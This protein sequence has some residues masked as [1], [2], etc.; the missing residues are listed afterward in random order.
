M[1]ICRGLIF[2]ALMLMIAIE[3]HSQPGAGS[4]P[5]LD[6]GREYQ[7]LR[8]R[9][10]PPQGYTRVTVDE[11]SFALWLRRLPL[12]PPGSRV[13]LFNGKPKADQTVHHAVIA[14]DTGSRNLQQCADAVIRLRAEYLF[15]RNRLDDI[16]F[17][18]TSGHPAAFPRWAQGER[19]M[20][21]GNR[22]TWRHRADADASHASLRRYLTNL[23]IYAG[24]YSLERE[25]VPKPIR[26][27]GIGDVFIQG[28]FPGHA[29]LVVD[30]AR[31]DQTGEAIF[32]L[33]QSYMPAQEM[34]LLRNPND[35]E[36]SPWYR[37]PA[38]GNL[39][40]P[41]WTFRT[42]DLRAFTE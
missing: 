32:L 18:F 12:K 34:H 35:P 23:F 8:E 6:A 7:S 17:H 36:L 39:I 31:Q 38:G 25:M 15:S 13:M 27:L 24:S 11:G 10:S 22:V 2:P 42:S 5:W 20:V 16:V 26:A 41:E 21:R 4:Y 30:L 37:L 33:A 29:V 19:P 9:I 28:G 3:V 1:R 40:T 14:L